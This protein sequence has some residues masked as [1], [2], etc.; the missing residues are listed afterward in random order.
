ME[1]PEGIGKE[2][3]GD[4]GERTMSEQISVPVTQE[5]LKVIFACCLNTHNLFKLAL[6]ND[7]LKTQVGNLTDEELVRW[8]N[9]IEGVMEKVEM[10]LTLK[11]IPSHNVG[12]TNPV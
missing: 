1:T 12:V 8:L 5:D 9:S 11:P 7:H 10:I 3:G 6:E 4:R 2:L